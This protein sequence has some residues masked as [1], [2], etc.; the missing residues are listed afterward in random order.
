MRPSSSS[1]ALI[2][3][4]SSAAAA[5][6]YVTAMIFSG[7]TWPDA[8]HSPS[9]CWIANV[10]PEPA[11]AGTMLSLGSGVMRPGRLPLR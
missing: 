6:V 8:T 2:L 9:L 7:D 5:S 3:S 1:F 10:L 11:P 4:R